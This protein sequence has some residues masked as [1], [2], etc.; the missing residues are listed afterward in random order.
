MAVQL[1]EA[2]ERDAEAHAA[3]DVGLPAAAGERD[4]RRTEQRVAGAVVDVEH[5]AD[6]LQRPALV[7]A[8]AVGRHRHRL[9]QRVA[10]GEVAARDD[11][12]GEQFVAARHDARLDAAHEAAAGAF[13]V[14]RQVERAQ[15]LAQPD[16]EL[17]Q[18]LV[19]DAAVGD[20]L[21]VVRAPAVDAQRQPALVQLRRVEDRRAVVPRRARRQRDR[22]FDAGEERR[23][24]RARLRLLVGELVG[25]RL[26]EPRATAAAAEVRAVE[27][28]VG[29][30]RQAA[31][32]SGARTR[33]G[34]RSDRLRAGRAV[35]QSTSAGNVART[36]AR[37][38]SRSGP[39]LPASSDSSACRSAA[40]TVYVACGSAASCLPSLRCAAFGVST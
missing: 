21:D 17:R 20:R 35:R 18:R 30:G 37:C 14:D 15:G 12:A 27:R 19:L 16:G 11:H 31:D 25:D 10:L 26:V 5:A 34:A 3:L 32:C 40:V 29:G 22:R 38:C 24:Q 9:R 8:Q 6:G 4:R 2:A 28:R 36:R 1:V 23:Q 13:E 39:P 33:C 7:V